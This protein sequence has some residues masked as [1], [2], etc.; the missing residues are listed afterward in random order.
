MSASR[1]VVVPNP[2]RVMVS[3]RIRCFLLVFILAVPLSLAHLSQVALEL[4]QSC[5]KWPEQQPGVQ[6]LNL[7]RQFVGD[8]CS[9]GSGRSYRRSA[10]TRYRPLI[11]GLWSLIS[12]LNAPRAVRLWSPVLESR[13]VSPSAAGL[14]QP[15]SL[16][17]PAGDIRACSNIRECRRRPLSPRAVPVPCRCPLAVSRQ[18]RQAGSP[19]TRQRRRPAARRRSQQIV[20]RVVASL[21]IADRSPAVGSADC[22]DVTDSDRWKMPLL[23]AA[24]T[25]AA[26]RGRSHEL[27]AAVTAAREGSA[28]LTAACGTSKRL[29]E[30][31]S[32][33]ATRRARTRSSPPA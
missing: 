9:R 11:G 21:I 3:D 16:H 5:G 33:A 28:Q 6:S 15:S 7:M 20:Q 18:P 14:R 25:G 4:I 30:A 22:S 23:D 26:A 17:Q 2:E 24:E 32:E 8:Q 1:Y 12:V 10:T 27:S 31:H 19:P 13:S 29:V